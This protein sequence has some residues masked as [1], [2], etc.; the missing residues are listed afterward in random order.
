MADTAAEDFVKQRSYTPICAIGASAGGVTALQNLFR[1][2]PDNLGLAYVVIL[3]LAPDQPSAMG[4]ILAACTKMPVHQ[5]ED[6][7]TLKPN[8]VYVIPPDRE[9]VINGDHVKAQD[10]SEPRGKR[11]PIDL[12][13]RSVAA[14]RGD[15]IAVILTGAGSDGASGVRAVKEAGG[16]VMVQ[17]PA[18]A[19]FPTMPQNAIATGAADFIGT[20]AR[21]ADRIGEV[22]QSKEAV[23]SLDADGAAND[24]RRIVGFLRTRTGHDF[25]SYK[26]TTVLR[27]VTRRMQ[28]ARADSLAEY[29]ELLRTS[30]EEAKEL[31]ADLL[32]SVT[33]F[34][35]DRAAFQALQHRAIRSIFD[36]TSEADDV[37]VWVVGCAT[38][39][40]AYSIAMLLLEEAARRKLQIPMQ[41][42]ASDLDEGA[43]A[44]AREGR[45]PR[46]IEADVPEERLQRFFID[47]GT[48]FRVRKEVRDLLLFANHS[49]LKDP[50]FTRLDL[51]ACRNLLIYLERSLQQQLC[52]IFHYGLR[53][54]GFLFLGSAE[55]ADGVQDLFTLV[56]REARLYRAQPRVSQPLPLLQQLPSLER[57]MIPAPG[58]QAHRNDAGH[59]A[60]GIHA[61]ALAQV[62]PPSVLVDEA[63]NVLHLSHSVGR[64][65]L[66]SDGPLSR[67]LTAVVRPELR[68]DLKLAL[69]RAFSRLP[70]LTHPVPVQFDGTRN[71]V[72]L[73]VQPV[74]Q[75]DHLAPR[76]VVFFLD[77]GP[78]PEDSE[79]EPEEARPDEVRR[80]HGALKSAQEA[81]VVSQHEHEVSVQD[82]RAANEELQSIN[83]EYRS[84]AEELETSKEELQSINEELQ[85]VNAELK[86]KLDGISVA[87]GDLQNIT[88]S[89]EIGTL[90]L[91]TDLRIR[92]FT[93]PVAELINITDHD[94]GRLVTDFT[95]RLEYEGIEEDVRRVL[96]T[97]TPL[98]REMRS[99]DGLWYV[100]RVR[101]YRTVEDR[102]N[103]AVVSFIDVTALH[104]A[105][106]RLSQSERE[107]R[108]LIDV[109]FQ[110]V[111]RMGAD[112]RGI[113]ELFSGGLLAD[114]RSPNESWLEHYIL[115]EDRPRVQ[116]VIDGAVATKGTFDLEHRV[117]RPDG[118]V[119]WTH[120]RATPMTD[121][122]TGEITEWFG[123]ATDITARRQAEAALT[124]SERRYR[125]LV[126]GVPQLVWMAADDGRWT[127]SS[128]QWSAYS[129]LT[130]RESRGQ[131]WMRAVH[132]DDRDAVTAAWENARATGNFEVEGRIGHV[133]S[134]QF[135]WFQTRAS[136]VVDA[137]GFIR[138]WL[139]TSTDVDDLR[140]L[141]EQQSVMVAELQHRTR[142]LIAVVRSIA[143]Q[144]A[145]AAGDLDTFRAKFGD[146]LAA[147]SRVQGLLARSDQAPITIETLIR[148]ELDALGLS[149]IRDRV[150]LRGP[151]VMLR[152]RDLQTFALAIHELAT[153]ARKHGA[154]AVPDG[155][156]R[157]IWRTVADPGGG[158]RLSLE[159][160]ETGIAPAAGAG[161]PSGGGYGRHLIEQAL[162]YS[163]GAT[164]SYVIGSDTVRFTIDVPRDRFLS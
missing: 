37:R 92:L 133:G 93:A 51:I 12:F 32:I 136:P 17:E 100:M 29:G 160:L 15:G 130:E 82:L 64:F 20:L 147:L 118:G 74:T 122:A 163:M 94:I 151:E 67:D 33:M 58:T 129:G 149:S 110:V 5:V 154:F 23:R 141:Q 27:R 24:L 155:Y 81:L 8:S 3:H 60:A 30:P 18:E 111:Y 16:V 75:D 69:S 63:Y 50:P 157:V 128:S 7:P 72:A 26:R 43:L 4:Q 55:S 109:S 115:P 91:D 39:E 77:N 11:A 83:E 148:T 124:E 48:H 9:L 41:V 123:S 34:F 98:D 86:V 125:V 96:R 152:N 36:G 116:A 106:T 90:F 62:A 70:T 161:P 1:L 145:E 66:H 31:F 127:W 153:N 19:A 107:L 146:R 97:L 85:T 13:F 139:G 150:V 80:L 144:T 46:S 120:S 59:D 114:T 156:L 68:L 117:R 44:T 61:T 38:G 140:R 54:G 47:E 102:I 45:Y 132:P 88:A 135:R 25:S 138:E 87:H 79:V 78:V 6:T 89:T 108:A 73:H 126:E 131:G 57:L 101:P 105:E 164:T 103:G 52:S 65:I 143:Q 119:G 21:L 134:Q 162:P 137:R 142:N 42:F 2:L 28:V 84:T 121:E 22:A 158:E 40:E 10:F 35:R 99:R 104:E 53:P 76:A 113:R 56:D 49:V 112:W 95:H 14:A 159:W 71:Q